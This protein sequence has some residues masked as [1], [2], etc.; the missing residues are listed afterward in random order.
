MPKEDPEKIDIN[1]DEEPVANADDAAQAMEQALKEASEAIQESEEPSGEARPRSRGAAPLP[2]EA[3]A[4]QLAKLQSE[5]DELRST[6]IRRQADFDNYKKR[7]ERERGEERQRATIVVI[8]QL[9]PVLDAFERALAAH[10]DPAYEEYRKGFE[11]IYR[12][13]L[14]A[15]GRYGLEPIEAVGAPFD[16]NLHHAVDR[17]E[18]AEHPEDTVVM[19]HQKGYRLRDMVIRPAMVRVSYRGDGNPPPDSPVN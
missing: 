14:D 19:E 15:L 13:V 4:V 7:L 11:L 18:S 16:P 10:A 8:E 17:A 6:L 12:Q 3:V 2:N 9:L 1:L 5:K